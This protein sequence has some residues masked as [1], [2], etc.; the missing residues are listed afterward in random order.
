MKL[1]WPDA[2]D[3]L[4]APELVA[5]RKVLV[6][7]FNEIVAARG[8]DDFVFQVAFIAG[9]VP[10]DEAVSFIRFATFMV[11]TTSTSSPGGPHV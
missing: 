4:E 5:N 8:P 3:N 1:Y 11:S 9:K 2:G 10:Y 7:R 6:E